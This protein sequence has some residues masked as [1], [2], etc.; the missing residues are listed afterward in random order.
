MDILATKCCVDAPAKQSTTT[1]KGKQENKNCFIDPHQQRSCCRHIT[2]TLLSANRLLL[3][4]IVGQ[5]H[6]VMA[7][8]QKNEGAQLRYDF[9]VICDETLY[10]LADRREYGFDFDDGVI[11]LVR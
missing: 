7:S 5:F 3:I 4:L 2:N 10:D 11:D 6:E 9:N 1:T 8:R